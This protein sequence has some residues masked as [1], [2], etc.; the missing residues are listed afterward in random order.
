MSPKFCK[1]RDLRHRELN[2]VRRLYRQHQIDVA[3][4]VPIGRILGV[5]L[6]VHQIFFDRKN[7]CD[8]RFEF[9]H[10]HPSADAQ[11]IERES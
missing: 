5:R 6:I 3:R 10:F 11:S 4:T 2:F 1:L 7:I 9:F 8:D